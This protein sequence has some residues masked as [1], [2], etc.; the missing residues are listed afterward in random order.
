MHEHRILVCVDPSASGDVCV[1]HAIS[2]ARA[3]RSELTLVHVMEPAQRAKPHVDALD[4]EIAR[5]EA[6]SY[7]ERLQGEAA[8][9]LG[10]AVNARLEQGHPPE[11][12]VALAQEIDADLTV[13]GSHGEG[14]VTPWNLGSTAHHVIAVSRGSVFIAPISGT[15]DV[16]APRRILAPL[17]GSRRT[18]GVLP[19]AARIA[20]AYG[21]ELILVH[22]VHELLPTLVLYATE[23]LD[24]ARELTAHLAICAKAYLEGLRIGLVREGTPVRTVV[25]CHANERHAILEISKREHADLVVVAAH[26]TAC[27]P[28]RTFGTVTEYLLAHARA[29]LLVLQDLPESELH[30][31]ELV[32][33]AAP[34]LRASFPPE[35]A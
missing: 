29:P 35:W 17:D 25:A 19:T 31:P 20:R 11:R 1:R 8:G 18:E 15:A 30:A 14:G 26:G 21:A 4:W 23:D 33:T 32:E 22:V 9:A 2:L 3:L 10:W 6:R 24:R 7:L 27:D 5:Q 34:A 28:E 13:L 16:A 12:I